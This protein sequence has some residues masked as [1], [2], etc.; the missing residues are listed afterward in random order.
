MRDAWVIVFFFQAE[1]G[2]RDYKVTGVQTCALPIWPWLS[3]HWPPSCCWIRRDSTPSSPAMASSLARG[4]RGLK[5]GIAWRTSK[6]FLCQWRRM[7]WGAVSPPSRAS[8]VLVSMKWSEVSEETGRHCPMRAL[9]CPGASASCPAMASWQSAG[10]LAHGPEIRGRQARIDL[11]SAAEMRGAAKAAIHGDLGD[12]AL[13]LGGLQQLA[14]AQLQAAV[15]YEGAQAGLAVRKGVVQMAL[16]AVERGGHG[17]HRQAREDRKSTRLNSSHLVIS[18]A[19]FCL[20]KN[21]PQARRRRQRDGFGEIH[22]GDPAVT[23]QPGDDGTIHPIRSV[24]RHEIYSTTDT[25]QRYCDA[26]PGWRHICHRVRAHFGQ[27]GGM[28]QSSA[29]TLGSPRHLT[30]SRG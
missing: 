8:G 14:H 20:K 9:P 25:A 1:D 28:T 30:T 11:E 18:Y 26:G 16:A 17:L 12:G 23:L 13:R 27:A 15:L 2:I 24:L 29:H 7:N 4:I 19:V 3:F 6:G 22:V 10:R 21:T 5:P